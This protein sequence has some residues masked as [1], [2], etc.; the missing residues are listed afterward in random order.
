MGC[1]KVFRKEGNQEEKDAGRD[2][3]VGFFLSFLDVLATDPG[4]PWLGAG[5][6][7][8]AGMKLWSGMVRPGSFCAGFV[9][10][11]GPIRRLSSIKKAGLVCWKLAEN[12]GRGTVRNCTEG[13][14]AKFIERG[15]MRA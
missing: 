8:V 7:K 5:A 1:V 4:A 11:E 6:A 2:F 15:P 3:P 10:D 9:M 12:W 14:G 13:G